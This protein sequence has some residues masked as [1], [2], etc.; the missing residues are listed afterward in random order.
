MFSLRVACCLD[1]PPATKGVECV[2][3]LKAVGCHWL[4]K[5][6]RRAYRMPRS[7]LSPST[8]N[9]SR[10]TKERSSREDTYRGCSLPAKVST[11]CGPQLLEQSTCTEEGGLKVIDSVE[12]FTFQKPPTPGSRL[13]FA[14]R[15]KRQGAR[16]RFQG[17]NQCGASNLIQCI[18]QALPLQPRILHVKGLSEK[19]KHCTSTH[20]YMTESSRRYGRAR[21]ATHSYPHTTC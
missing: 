9:P 14:P 10:Q 19:G 1:C 7:S 3:G 8:P 13:P 21:R 6:L 15:K 2:I 18:G 20:A 16:I 11:T 5:H 12:C 4:A 17:S